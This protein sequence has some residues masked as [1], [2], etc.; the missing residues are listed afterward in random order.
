[1][2]GFQDYFVRMD[3]LGR[4]TRPE[5]YG[6]EYLRRMLREHNEKDGI[7]LLAFE[8]Q[9]LAGFGAAVVESRIEDDWFGSTPAMMGRVSELFVAGPYGSQGIGAV[10]MEKLEAELRAKGCDYIWVEV[11]ASNARAH[12]FYE[13]LG[14]ADR[15]IQMIKR[16]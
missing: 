6:E 1:L 16:L 3:P 5:G 9:H 7:L 11:F 10:L 12:R 2:D 13:R 8:G 15:D 4:L 14:F